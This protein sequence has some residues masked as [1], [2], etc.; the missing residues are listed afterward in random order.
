MPNDALIR[1]LAALSG[2]PPAAPRDATRVAGKKKPKFPKNTAS[3]SARTE[4][5]DKLTAL[6]EEEARRQQAEG[7]LRMNP[8]TSGVWLGMQANPLYGYAG[9]AAGGARIAKDVA[10]GEADGGT[11]LDAALLAA[12]FAAGKVGRLMGRGASSSAS[13]AARDLRSTAD[14]E[15]D[16]R[17]A[18][19]LGNT[20]KPREVP[21]NVRYTDT[22]NATSVP[23]LGRAAADSIIT[24]GGRDMLQFEHF[25][26]RPDLTKL[27]PAFMGTGRPGA[28]RK[29]PGRP[30]ANHVY[31]FN[32]RL[33]RE[34]YFENDYRYT[35]EVPADGVYDISADP[36]GIIPRLREEGTLSSATMEHAIKNAGFAGYRNKADYP[37]TIKL[38]GE[39]EL[40][41]G[42]PVTTTIHRVP[43][44]PAEGDNVKTIPYG[45]RPTGVPSLAAAG[46][47]VAV[48]GAQALGMATPY[49]GPRTHGSLFGVEQGGRVSQS[50]VRIAAEPVDEFGMSLP[51]APRT[52]LDS[53][54][55][56]AGKIR[57]IPKAPAAPKAPPYTNV[58]K[59]ASLQRAID[60]LLPPEQ[61]AG[62]WPAEWHPAP[63]DEFAVVT[64]E[65]PGGVT[66]E[67]KV[68]AGRLAA[69]DRSL[70]RRGLTQLPVVGQYTDGTSG[71]TL[72]E[73]GSF[74]PDISP[75]EAAQ[76]GRQFG[77]NSVLT[78]QGLHDLTDDVLYPSNGI[79]PTDKLPMTRLPNGQAFDANLDFG[80]GKPVARDPSPGLTA[81]ANTGPYII[82]PP[83]SGTVFNESN[84][85]RITPSG[86]SLDRARSVYPDPSTVDWPLIDRIAQ[87][88][89]TKFT[90]DARRGAREN[91]RSLGW[92]DTSEMRDGF[93]SLLGSDQGLKD[94]QMAMRLTSPPSAG[95]QVFPKNLRYGSYGYYLYKNGITPDKLR[96]ERLVLPEG[97][98][99]RYQGNVNGGWA[100]IIENGNLDPI[101]QPKTYRHG[102]QPALGKWGSMVLD[103]HVGYRTGVPGVFDDGTLGTG[104]PASWKYGK[105]TDANDKFGVG[106][107]HQRINT[108]PSDAMYPLI[109]DPFLE[110][111][112]R[113]GVTPPQYLGAGWTVQPGVDDPRT[114]IELYNDMFRRTGALHGI[115]PLEAFK[116]W[117]QGS[118]PLWGAAG[119]AALPKA[120]PNEKGQKPTQ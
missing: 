97:Y 26:P 7:E 69:F 85:G 27:D 105:P 91:P 115:T 75:A 38:F 96:N 58:A 3:I 41:P 114:L 104:Y 46:D 40:Q 59:Q 64:P 8:L 19:D 51:N 66:A 109:E 2:S 1:A 119:A 108:S 33:T 88:V 13:T 6:R 78:R 45:R 83:S 25:S 73:N 81:L 14:I 71:A 20:Y 56:Q 49:E 10:T 17:A 74:I 113:M 4:A 50:G 47:T 31:S 42:D 44:K 37:G 82:T 60:M 106:G 39:H 54:A 79:T 76:L 35:G 22:P 117:A 120:T 101:K 90:P 100:D 102:E 12:P 111:A 112:H 72:T 21:D 36:L 9:L 95:T 11:A 98:K 116:R 61:R 30:N 77:Q 110:E 16:T 57:K 53:A 32:E 86:I 29:I 48:R 15:N 28:E 23:A 34:P 118:I 24:R 80:A 43:W 18:L 87:H 63:K 92:Y 107:L 67:P 93:Q 62:Q 94:F 65:N 84:L 70:S 103:R 99:H 55:A 68:N 5:G 52:A 89:R